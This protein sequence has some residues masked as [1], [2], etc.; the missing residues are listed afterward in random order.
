MVVIVPL[1]GVV[2]LAKEESNDKDVSEEVSVKDDEVSEDISEKDVLEI[3]LMF[4]VVPM[5][6]F[7]LWFMSKELDPAGFCLTLLLFS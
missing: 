4:F 7:E 2:V 1:E 5:L 6:S 3:L